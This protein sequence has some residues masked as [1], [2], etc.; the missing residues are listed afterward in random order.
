MSKCHFFL[1]ISICATFQFLQAEH[2]FEPDYSPMLSY[3]DSPN[4]EKYSEDSQEYDEYD[5]RE[6][7][8]NSFEN[9]HSNNKQNYQEDEKDDA[10]KNCGKCGRSM[11]EKGGRVINGDVVKPFY[12]YP[13]IVPVVNL[14]EKLLCSG[15]IISKKF[16]LTSARCLFNK[17]SL[18]NPKCQGQNTVKECYY[19]ALNYVV[20]LLGKKILRTILDVNRIIPHPQFDFTKYINDIAL[21]EVI[22]TFECNERTNPICLATEEDLYKKGQKVSVAGWGDKLKEKNTTLPRTLKEG[23]ME[24]V[25][26]KDCMRRGLPEEIVKQYYCA[27]GTK[28]SACQ[29]DAGSS[30]F[31]KSKKT[32][33]SLGVASH[34]GSNICD[35]TWPFTFAK[36]LY[37]L[38]WI[39]EHVKDLPKP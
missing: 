21:V 2:S 11:I 36:T 7:D 18:S 34:Q 27:V 8:S 25:S 17:T 31:I 26:S 10:E 20:T 39:K 14:R 13:W 9:K 38:E 28:Q 24:E 23:T 15:A 30:A 37:F 19:S 12:K 1:T 35:V 6:E 16:V 4:P 3:F 33:Y 32:F 5:S 22:K 29:G